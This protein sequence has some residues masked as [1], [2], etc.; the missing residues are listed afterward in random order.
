M[1]GH[2]EVN[3]K[4]LKLS[5]ANKATMYIIYL[6]ANNLYRHSMIKLFRTKI[7]AWVKPKM[8]I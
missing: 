8:L 6:D 5:D 3:N 1:T 7:L 2:A 4:L